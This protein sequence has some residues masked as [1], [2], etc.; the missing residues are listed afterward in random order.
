MKWYA[1]ALAIQPDYA[2]AQYRMGALEV[3]FGEVGS[4]LEHIGQAAKMDPA[5]SGEISRRCDE[6]ARYCIE[7]KRYD[8]ARLLYE[9]ALTVSPGDLWPRVHLGE[10]YELLGD[11]DAA[12]SCYRAVLMAVP[13]SPV[14]AKKLHDLLQRLPLD[15]G[16]AMVEWRAIAE[17]H[18]DAAIPQ[19][20]LGVSLQQAGDKEGAVRAYTQALTLNPELPEVRER[21][22]TLIPP[23]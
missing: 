4:G 8:D 22:G 11:A 3:A 12:L 1:E 6:F 16:A 5:L 13:D 9:T 18:P 20:Y 19:Y 10:L 7:R 14:T 21:L 15:E 17:K 23:K 2:P